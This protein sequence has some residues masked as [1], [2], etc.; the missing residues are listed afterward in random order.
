MR[1]LSDVAKFSG[2]IV[3]GVL[4]LIATLCQIFP[5]LSVKISEWGAHAMNRKCAATRIVLGLLFLCLTISAWMFAADMWRNMRRPDPL[6]D[7]VVKFSNQVESFAD[8]V[9]YD[10]RHFSHSDFEVK[11]EAWGNQIVSDLRRKGQQ[12]DE[13]N[14]FFNSLDFR[15]SNDCNSNAVKRI[16]SASKEMR[17]LSDN[18]TD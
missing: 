1:L 8:G 13:L 18:L 5:S 15:L 12:S 2:V 14:E 17:R 11:F 16:K 9:P 10:G 7:E 6:K 4:S 3:F